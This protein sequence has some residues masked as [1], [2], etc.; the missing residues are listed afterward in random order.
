MKNFVTTTVIA[1]VVSFLGSLLFVKNA[2]AIT[3]STE[4]GGRVESVLNEFGRGI[5]LSDLGTRGSVLK[6]VKMG[7]GTII[8]TTSITATSTGNVDMAVVGARSGDICVIGLP[9]TTSNAGRF[10]VQSSQASSTSGYCTAQLINLTGA[11][12]DPA[13][14]N[15][16]GSSSTYQLF[17]YSNTF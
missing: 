5:Q 12:R 13:S 10:V 4:L 2:P 14:V 16:F 17:R 9:A 15:G 6:L 1:L 3:P 7:T 11:S 8:N